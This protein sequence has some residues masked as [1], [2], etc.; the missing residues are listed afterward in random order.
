MLMNRRNQSSEPVQVAR[1]LHEL[2]SAVLW[3]LHDYMK[4]KTKNNAGKLTRAYEAWLEYVEQAA[5]EKSRITTTVVTTQ[6][7]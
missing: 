2:Q 5:E 1:R 3:A 6:I 7:A 4:A